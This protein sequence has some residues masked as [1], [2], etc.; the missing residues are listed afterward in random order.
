M[1]P[2]GYMMTN[3]TAIIMPWAATIRLI[4]DWL[5]PAL[6]L[7]PLLDVS[8]PVL[9]PLSEL[10]PELPELLPLLDEPSLPLL[11]AAT[12]GLESEDT[13]ADCR[14][15]V[16]PSVSSCCWMLALAFVVSSELPLFHAEIQLLLVLPRLIVPPS[17]LLQFVHSTL[18][19][20]VS[21]STPEPAS[22]VSWAAP[23]PVFSVGMTW[24]VPRRGETVTLPL[25][26]VYMMN[27]LEPLMRVPCPM[28][29]HEYDVGPWI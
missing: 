9:V 1:V 6:P 22:R 13:V 27:M 21:P 20:M 4:S 19:R 10:S 8:D 23:D 15:T 11:A 18:A 3:V 12:K 7:I 24:L 5:G 17:Q 29:S 2:T 25:P 26:S 14:L 28:A 16:Q